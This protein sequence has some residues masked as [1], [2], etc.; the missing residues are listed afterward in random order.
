MAQSPDKIKRS[1][2][3]SKSL[4]EEIKIIAANERKNQKDIWDDVLSFFIADW[5]AKNKVK[6]VGKNE[7]A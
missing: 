3:A 1:I 2:E 6:K 4:F 7:K 5:K